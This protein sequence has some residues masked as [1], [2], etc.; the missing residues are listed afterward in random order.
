[1]AWLAW[2]EAI[3]S[4][5]HGPFFPCGTLLVA[6]NGTDQQTFW[7]AY[8]TYFVLS[9]LSF[10]ISWTTFKTVREHAAKLPGTLISVSFYNFNRLVESNDIN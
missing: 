7:V 4:S 9:S 10:Y 8:T 3:S 5:L 6:C 1:M 2:E